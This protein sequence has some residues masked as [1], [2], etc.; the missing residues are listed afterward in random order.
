[1]NNK[2]GILIKPEN[3]GLN[4]VLKKWLLY[5]EPIYLFKVECKVLKKLPMKSKFQQFPIES[6]KPIMKLFAG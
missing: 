3:F 5:L 2:L 1:M 4:Q 6:L